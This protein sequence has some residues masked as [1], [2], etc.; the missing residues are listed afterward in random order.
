MPRRVSIA[1]PNTA[2]AGKEVGTGQFRGASAGRGSRA[3]TWSSTRAELRFA[4]ELGAGE[5]VRDV[6]NRL[7]DGGLR[8][9]RLAPPCSRR[10]CRLTGRFSRSGRASGCSARGTRRGCRRQCGRGR[11]QTRRLRQAGDGKLHV[12]AGG[13]RAA[14]GRRRTLF[15]LLHHLC[16]RPSARISR[17]WRDPSIGRAGPPSA[18]T[19]D[20]AARSSGRRAGVEISAWVRSPPVPPSKPEP[21][22]LGGTRHPNV[23]C[24]SAATVRT[25]APR[26]PV[27][28]GSGQETQTT[29]QES[30]T[31]PRVAAE[32]S[33]AVGVEAVV[34][35]VG[36]ALLIGAPARRPRSSCSTLS[37]S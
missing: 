35:A 19:S 27:Q 25:S 3:P 29:S 37:L 33:V 28:S 10:R 23:G 14:S 26:L 8:G 11:R 16:S 1:S 24:P 20:A 30:G 7:R 2:A 9:G 21:G 36:D 17:P 32:P 34:K 6:S 12:R 4:R 31:E 13:S 5:R 15:P 22:G 18:G